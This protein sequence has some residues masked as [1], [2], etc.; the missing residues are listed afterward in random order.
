MIYHRR[1]RRTMITKMQIRDSVT[2]GILPL[3][4]SAELT[5][6][7][8][9]WNEWFYTSLRFEHTLIPLHRKEQKDH[10][11]SIANELLILCFA[12]SDVSWKFCDSEQEI[13]LHGHRRKDRDIENGSLQS[14]C[15]HSVNSIF[16]YQGEDLKHLWHNLTAFG[17][18][19]SVSI[20]LHKRENGWK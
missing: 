20:A 3:K 9:F 10:Y 14:G 11:L 1:P 15:I 18:K 17:I 16:L 12:A 6:Y 2:H 19:V 7:A 8:T 13:S 5:I 4:S